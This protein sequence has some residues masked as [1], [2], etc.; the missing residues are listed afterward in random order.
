MNAK[1]FLDE[2]GREEATRVAIAAGTNY[3]YFTQIASGHRRPSVDLAL[4]LITASDDRLSFE[5]LLL[6]RTVGNA[7]APRS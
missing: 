1:D 7:E 4:R 2:F 3:V 5:A 6:Q